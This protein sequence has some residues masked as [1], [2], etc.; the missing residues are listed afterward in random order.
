[1]VILAV[2]IANVA[3]IF[4]ALGAFW[5]ERTLDV[6]KFVP[7]SGNCFVYTVTLFTPSDTMESAA[8]EL[9]L[10]EDDKLLEPGHAQHEAIRHAGQGRF[11]H[12]GKEIYMSSSDNSDPRTNARVYKITYPL[13]PSSSVVIISLLLTAIVLPFAAATIEGRKRIYKRYYFPVMAI[14]ISGALAIIPI[15]M[16]LRT[17][18][19]KQHVF[20]ALHRLPSQL[21]PTLNAKGYRDT[22]HETNKSPGSVRILVLGDSLTF[23]SGVAD[24]DIYPRLLQDLAASNVEVISLAQNGWGTA[25]ELAALRRDG[26]GYSPDIVVVG[27]VTNDPSPPVTEPIGQSTPWMVFQS[28]SRNM[29][30]FRLL[31]FRINLL[32][33]RSGW[34][35]S[36]SDWETDLYDPDKR[37]RAEWEKSVTELSQELRSHGITAYAFLLIGPTQANELNAWKFKILDEVFSKAGFKTQNLLEHYIETFQGVDPTSLFALPDD[38]HPGRKVHEFYARELW[39]VLKPDTD[40]KVKSLKH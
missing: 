8:S 28:I 27:V 39:K 23:G 33:E 24:D 37:Y 7:N 31:D 15:E 29:M 2:V 30:L 14:T 36:Y 17:D 11:S 12:W 16:F 13:R 21:R 25:D 3:L 38:S 18:Y 32:A 40:M 22:E 19:S 20:G 5:V 1:L 26:L 9:K 35:Y 4:S 6:Q 34:K 10:F